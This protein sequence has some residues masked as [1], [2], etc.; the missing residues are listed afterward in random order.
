MG[1]PRTTSPTRSR[2]VP[3]V[4]YRRGDVV[5]ISLTAKTLRL[6]D[7]TVVAVGRPRP[8]GREHGHHL[9]HPRGGGE[10][11]ADEDDPGGTRDQATPAADVRGRRAGAPAEGRPARRRR[12]WRT[13]GRRGVR[14]GRRAAAGHAPRVPRAVPRGEHHVG[15]G[16]PAPAAHVHREVQRPRQDRARAARRHGEVVVCRRPHVPLGRAPGVRGGA[17]GRHDRLGRGGRGSRTVERSGRHRPREPAGGDADAPA[18]RRRLG[19]SATSPMP[20][21]RTAAP[22]RWSRRSPCRWG[23]T[24]RTR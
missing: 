11:P 20:R 13:H 18:R 12:R 2:A 19:R 14:R 9:R 6:D 3:G 21:V 8:G 22:C 16:G 24:S 10:R 17:P 5:R 7:G 23:A 4:R 1:C 15:R